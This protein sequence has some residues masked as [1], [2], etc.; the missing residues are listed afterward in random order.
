MKNTGRPYD[1]GINTTSRYIDA[2]NE[3]LY[4]FG[5]GLSYTTFEY[6]EIVLDKESITED[7]FLNISVTIKNT[8]RRAGEEVVQLYIR[9]NVASV[10]RPVKEL[11]DFEKIKLQPGESHEVDFTLSASDLAFY[12]ED[13]SYGWEKGRFTVFV[14]GNSRD[15]KS[16]VFELK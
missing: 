7:E 13:M 16:A 8:G 11:K 1:P 10:T 4:P 15:V 6:G 3:P 2:S 14:G 9:D 12:R 5:Y